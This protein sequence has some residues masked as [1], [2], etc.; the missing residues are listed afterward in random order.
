M[1]DSEFVQVI[2]SKYLNDPL[3]KSKVRVLLLEAYPRNIDSEN[4]DLLEHLE[5]VS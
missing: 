5:D 1:K 2:R 3:F 4:N